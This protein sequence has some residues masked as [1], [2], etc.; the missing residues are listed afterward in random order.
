MN[1]YDWG[2]DRSYEWRFRPRA[3]RRYD[4]GY[5][6]FA[7]WHAGPEGSWDWGPA[8]GERWS[9]GPARPERFG[10]DR[11]IYGGPYPAFGGYPGGYDRG[12]Y[13]GRR[14]PRGFGGA[15][16]R[17][18]GREYHPAAGHRPVPPPPPPAWARR[19]RYD[20]GVVSEP[21]LPEEVYEQHPELD[22]PQRHLPDRWPSAAA[23]GIGEE[24][25]DEEIRRAV[26]ENLFN[27]TWVHADRIQVEVSAQVVTLKGEVD[28]YL[29]ARY[30]WDDAWEAAGVR[31]VINQLTV[32]TDAPALPHGDVLP[33]TGG[34]RKGKK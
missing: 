32:R 4:L 26:R 27:D 30:A 33:Q 15:R 3:P 7:D 23:S 21:F 20:A 25:D 31:G 13:Y 9:F 5:R 2:W 12:M 19:E 6:R 24:H 34:G 10:Y 1:R 28:D 29:E 16:V 14:P 17:G 22:R 11:G 8:P 18:Y